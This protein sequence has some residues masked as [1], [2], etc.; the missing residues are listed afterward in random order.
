M[1]PF[2]SWSDYYLVPGD[3]TQTMDLKNVP[4][5]GGNILW[6]Q[7]SRPFGGPYLRRRMRAPHNLTGR[8][9]GNKLIYLQVVHDPPFTLGQPLMNGGI[10]VVL[11]SEIAGV[12]IGTYVRRVRGALRASTD[13]IEKSSSSG[14]HDYPS[15]GMMEVIEK[16]P[17]FNW[18]LLLGAAV[19]TGTVSV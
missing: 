1:P 15:L 5:N 17:K 9:F 4:L 11:R 8:W 2:H 18:S 14:I 6:N 10:G 16:G 12:E 19:M 3:T 13:V 7:T